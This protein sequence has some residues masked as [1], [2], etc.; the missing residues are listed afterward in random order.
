[1]NIIH[2][3][4]YY[5][6]IYRLDTYVNVYICYRSK[7]I[8]CKVTSITMILFD[9][10]PLCGK[11]ISFSLSIISNKCLLI[12]F[13]KVL[14]KNIFEVIKLEL[15]RFKVSLYVVT[16]SIPFKIY[17]TWTRILTLYFG[18]C[19]ICDSIVVWISSISFNMLLSE[20]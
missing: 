15:L 5:L 17:S 14:P 9:I 1:M 7:F 2:F 12:T 3:S 8:L 13:F 16:L 18:Y 6:S 19:S 11:F 4:V 20:K 10:Q